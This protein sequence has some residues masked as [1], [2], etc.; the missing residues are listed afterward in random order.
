[1]AWWRGQASISYSFTV[2]YNNNTMVYGNSSAMIPYRTV[3]RHFLFIKKLQTQCY[4]MIQ[5]YYTV[6]KI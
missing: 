4:G 6:N 1:M 5:Q 3:H 2:Q